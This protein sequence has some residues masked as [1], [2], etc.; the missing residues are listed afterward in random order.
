MAYPKVQLVAS[1][2]VNATVLYD[3][4]LD[5]NRKVGRDGFDAG[6]PTWHGD[7]GAVGGYDDYRTIRFT[8][9]FESSETTAQASLATLGQLL[10]ADKSWLLIQQRQSSA[11]VWARVWRSSPAALSWD[12]VQIR[13]ETG[14]GSPRGKYELAL[15]LTADPYLV[16]A[17]VTLASG[18][19]NNDPAAGSNPNVLL[20]GTPVG[21]APSPAVVQVG[22][23]ADPQYRTVLAQITPVS[24]SYV[25]PVVFQFGASDGWTANNPG[26][27]TTTND[28]AYSGGSYRSATFS[29]S[30]FTRTDST[31]PPGTYHVLLRCAPVS[32]ALVFN[33]TFSNGPVADSPSVLRTF[34]FNA[35]ATLARYVSFGLVQWLYGVFLSEDKIAGTSPASSVLRLAV[36]RLSGSGNL[37]LDALVL[38]PTV[39]VA[40]TLLVGHKSSLTVTETIDSELDSVYA[41][42]G[43]AYLSQNTTVEGGSPLVH[44]GV[45]NALHLVEQVGDVLLVDPFASN[46][47]RKATTFTVSVQYRPYWLWPRP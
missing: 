40:R 42:S 5:R 18:T 4:N 28:G 16:G 29:G 13:T 34:N 11:P 21:D 41:L 31:I 1:P 22:Y 8:H 25:K 39:R 47:D 30:A 24:A 27:D 2:D 17:Q 45:P 14:A 15:E 19:V 12:Q 20:L 35:S 6:V 32:S 38:V 43:G 3:F 33:A 7:P 46:G 23:S 44:P 10:T 36:D 37:R 9:R 26:A